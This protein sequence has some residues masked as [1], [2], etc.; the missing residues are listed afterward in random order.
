VKHHVKESKCHIESW[1]ATVKN[2]EKKELRK[3]CQIKHV[4]FQ[5]SKI[6]M[7]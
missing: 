7:F 2:L 4:L 3:L 6:G 5:T 1:L